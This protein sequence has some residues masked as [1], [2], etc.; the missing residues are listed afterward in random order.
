LIYNQLTYFYEI[1][2][3]ANPVDLVYEFK[4]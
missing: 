2:S 4:T 1:D 3:T